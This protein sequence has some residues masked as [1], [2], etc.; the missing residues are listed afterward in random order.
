MWIGELSKKYNVSK[1]TIRYY[2]QEGLIIPKSKDK[3]YNFGEKSER[4]LQLI[5]KLKALE[6]SIKEIHEVLSIGRVSNLVDEQDIDRIISIYID[7]K[8]ELLIKVG[9]L[10]D[11]IGN[12]DEQIEQLKSQKETSYKQLGIPLRA[13]NLLRCPSCN[14]SL[15][16]SDVQMSDAYIYSGVSRCLCG[17]TLT[18]EEGV[19]HT[20]N[21]NDSEYDKPDLTRS[22][23]KDIPPKLISD[24]QKAYNWML[25]EIK[26]H[27]KHNVVMETHINAYFFLH[28]HIEAFDE[29][30]LFIVVDKFPEMLKM[31][32]RRLERLG[33]SFDILFIA[34]N[35]TNYP[36]KEN[37]VDLFIDYFGI[38]EHG[39][40][41][42]KDFIAEID[43]YFK[44]DAHIVGTCFYFDEPSHS[45]QNL[46]GLYPEASKDNFKSKYFLDMLKRSNYL[47]EK[48]QHLMAIGDT[49]GSDAF[50]FH[51]NDE[52]LHFYSY[53]A[54]KH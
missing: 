16:F 31:Y 4:D 52:P 45:Q 7:K 46:I 53:Y 35:S 6:F 28:Q 21:E 1:D 36:I 11:K 15:S 33:K 51:V 20:G 9:I 2:I 54:K 43:S 48:Y 12:I 39:F 40:F 29:G 14:S 50:V 23:Y 19:L 24:F 25:A 10:K 47:I 44:K 8:E 26:R 13:M 37:V 41:S 38:N 3:Y 22:F 5:L 27:G 30:T 34:D 32:K 17:C 18:V 42:D 49:G